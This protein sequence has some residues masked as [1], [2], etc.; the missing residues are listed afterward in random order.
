MYKR[1][2]FLKIWVKV[3]EK[4]DKMRRQEL[5]KKKRLKKAIN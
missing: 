1:H 5:V 3:T 4:N 2:V